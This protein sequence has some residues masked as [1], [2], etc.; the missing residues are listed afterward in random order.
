LAGVNGAARVGLWLSIIAAAV[1][2]ITTLG[3]MFYVA[4]ITKSNADALVIQDKMIRDSQEKIA[5]LQDRLTRIEVAQNEVETQFCSADDM[6]NVIHASDLRITAV[7]WKKV[8][9]EE[10]QISNAYY[11]KVCQRHPSSR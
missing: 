4:F 11:P 7:L 1:V 2:L 8:F 6:C 5:L 3:G 10:F 9:G